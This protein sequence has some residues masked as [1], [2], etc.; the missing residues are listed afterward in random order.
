M[1]ERIARARPQP[2]PWD[3]KHR[4]GAL[5]DLDFIQQSLLLRHAHE[6]PSLLSGPAFRRL[7]EAGILGR[8]DGIACADALVFWHGL[9]QTL[10]VLLGKVESAAIPPELLDRALDAAV[11]GAGL[12]VL[13]RVAASVTAV[14]TRVLGGEGRALG[15]LPPGSTL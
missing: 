12:A 13:D 1:R 11:P 10:R 14:Y 4:R 7:V 8:Q 9:Q 2:M 15:P 6:D 5:V 3:C